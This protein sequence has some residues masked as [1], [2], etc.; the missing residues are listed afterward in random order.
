MEESHICGQKT[1]KRS[2]F[3]IA[4]ELEHMFPPAFSLRN[5]ASEQ[6]NAIIYTLP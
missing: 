6:S 5:L 1:K 3:F 2:A 4:T